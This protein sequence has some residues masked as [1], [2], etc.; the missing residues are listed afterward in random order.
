M[1]NQPA[2]LES[3]LGAFDDPIFAMDLDGR[4]TY[5]TPAVALWTGR[6]FDA[7][8][9]YAFAGSLPSDESNRFQSALK[10][11]ADAKTD[12]VTLDMRLTP[13]D[14][15]EQGATPVELKLIAIS[16]SNG[17]ATQIVGRIRD[18]SGEIANEAAANLQSTHLL[19]LVENVAD[20]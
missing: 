17:K 15:G 14:A 3:L 2:L 5:A 10:R 20:V 12:H 16:G 6:P 4:V 18:V 19:G 9:G 11:I 1:V 7:N 13:M 8:A